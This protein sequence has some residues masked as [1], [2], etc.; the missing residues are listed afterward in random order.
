[1]SIEVMG[2]VWE[3]PNLTTGQKLVLLALADHAGVDGRCYPSTGR[4]G[5]RCGLGERQVRKHLDALEEAGLITKLERRRR[6]DGTLGVWTYQ[7]N[8]R[9]SSSASPPELQFQEKCP[10]VPVVHRNSSSAHETSVTEPPPNQHP[11]PVEDGFD[12]FW[13]AY[14]RKTAKADARKA[15][16]Q[17]TKTT[18]PHTIL[19]GLEKYGFSLDRRFVPYPASWL[20]GLRW[21][22]EQECGSLSAVEALRKEML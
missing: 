19:A 8:H 6:K 9:S 4:L 2:W 18:D 21:T 13:A 17:V 11:T 16:K 14:P 7:V 1:M 10:T 12:R 5:E 15:W 22:D 3:Q 20:R